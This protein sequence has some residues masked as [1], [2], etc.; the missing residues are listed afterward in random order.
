MADRIAQLNSRPYHFTIWTILLFILFTLTAMLIYPGGTISDPSLEGYS[1][2]KNFFSD[3]G[4]I[5]S[6]NG[7]RNYY[8]AVLFFIALNGV[9]LGLITYFVTAPVLFRTHTMSYVLAWFGSF[10]GIIAGLGYIGVAFTPADL[11]LDPHVL[12]VYVA[13]LNIPV[14]IFFYAFAIFLMPG[15]PQRYA[16]AFIIFTVMLLA[17]VY[18]LF[19]GI[20]DLRIQATG[21][22][23]IAYASLI[24]MYYQ[25]RGVIQLL[26][27]KTLALDGKNETMLP[28]PRKLSL[29]K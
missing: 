23:L 14:A 2:T 7:E 6:H 22:K 28:S 25:A 10:F 13:F 17:Y 27:K 19:S 24:T 3:L 9:G 21:Q 26:D 18:L 1:F 8:A 20:S 5:E 4:M 11:L 15:Y 16:L 12:A 29:E